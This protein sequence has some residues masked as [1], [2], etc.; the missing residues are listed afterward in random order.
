MYILKFEEFN[1]GA[2]PQQQ[3]VDQWKRIRKLTRKTDIGDKI[4]DMSKQGA[5]IQYIHNAID[6]G[7]ESQQDW[8]KGNKNFKPYKPEGWEKDYRLYYLDQTTSDRPK[9]KKR[10]K[11]K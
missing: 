9:V 1:E 10:R 6:K 5:N 2:L 8:A 7:I 3:S 4:S 11:K